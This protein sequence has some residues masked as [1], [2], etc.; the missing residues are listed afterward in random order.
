MTL[1]C[2]FWN[3]VGKWEHELI[4]FKLKRNDDIV[5][6][7]S[8]NLSMKKII[9][10]LTETKK[11]K[12]FINRMNEMSVPMIKTNMQQIWV[13]FFIMLKQIWMN[14]DRDRDRMRKDNNND[15]KIKKRKFKQIIIACR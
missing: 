3:A 10:T 2:N 15:R 9:W 6:M 13:Q 4:P 1:Q 5:W 11:K 8:M 14:Y 7:M 12:K